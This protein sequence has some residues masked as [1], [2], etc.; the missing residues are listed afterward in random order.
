MLKS[1]VLVSSL[2]SIF[3]S[4]IA[5]SILSV[6]S[7]NGTETVQ[8]ELRDNSTLGGPP[9]GLTFDIDYKDQGRL[10]TLQANFLLTGTISTCT[11]MDPEATVRDGRSFVHSEAQDVVIQARVDPGKTLQFKYL[12]WALFFMHR[13][14]NQDKGSAYVVSA[15]GIFVD[16]QRRG[17]VVLAIQGQGQVSG[18]LDVVNATEPF[19]IKVNPST[20]ITA[21]DEAIS[22]DGM[23][24]VQSNQTTMTTANEDLRVNFEF[25]SS[26][27][28]GE[29]NLFLILDNSILGLATDAFDRDVSIRVRNP[30]FNIQAQID[31]PTPR[32]R[33]PPYN[34]RARSIQAM[35]LSAA[36]IYRE[37]QF[38]E[39]AG[40][41]AV[42]N[43]Q[44]M[45]VDFK[46]Y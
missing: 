45:T 21:R 15:V 27:D 17:F 4:S 8:Y 46:Q 12:Q 10:D 36:W 23:K 30:Y 26:T 43:T 29:N 5:V 24:A 22:N 3:S 44:I 37:R 20:I 41:I 31:P 38:R 13:G 34:T 16:G 42:G 9:P 32:R 2:L 7:S 25:T 35:Y 39:F 19:P 40:S 1:L 33:S 14:L 6:A 11:R 18:S 28:L